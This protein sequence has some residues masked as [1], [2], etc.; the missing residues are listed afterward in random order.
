MST[1]TAGVTGPR[2]H[3]LTGLSSNYPLAMEARNNLSQAV[4]CITFPLSVSYP[5]VSLTLLATTS[6]LDNSG[7]AAKAA[8]AMRAG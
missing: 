8:C 3:F 7:F 4:G 2:P 1:A 5:V 6:K